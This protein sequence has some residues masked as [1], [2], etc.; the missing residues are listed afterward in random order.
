MAWQKIA[1]PTGGRFTKPVVSMRKKTA[2][3]NR[4]ARDL[5]GGP[6]SKFHLHMDTERR[7]IGF[8]SSAGGGVTIT[9]NGVSIPLH[10][11][12]AELKVAD[13]EV[14]PLLRS[15]EAGS[16]VQFYFALPPKVKNP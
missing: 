6:G 5:M 9:T 4:A 14:M 12:L 16:P 13:G 2:V 15:T 1:V 8:Q 11:T 3:L 7:L 10:R